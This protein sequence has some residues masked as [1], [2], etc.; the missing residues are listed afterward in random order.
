MVS[1]SQKKNSGTNI[2]NYISSFSVAL[3]LGYDIF[4]KKLIN[5]NKDEK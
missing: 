1:G 5:W 2:K 3:V 4:P